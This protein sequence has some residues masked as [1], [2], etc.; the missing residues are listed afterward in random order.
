[1][2]EPD[3]KHTPRSRLGSQTGG[4]YR[5]SRVRSAST[6]L[7]SRGRVYEPAMVDQESEPTDEPWRAKLLVIGLALFA[8]IVA[9]ALL[10]TTPNQPEQGELLPRI[11][12]PLIWALAA[13]LTFIPLQIRLGLPNIGW[14]GMV[15][16]GL[17]AYLLAYVPAPTGPIFELP[18]LPV[19]L[20]LFLTTFYATVTVVMPI[21]YLVGQRIYKLRIDRFDAG[22]ARRQAYEVGLLVVASLIMAAMRVLSPLTFSLMA[23]IIVLVEALM[24]SRAKASK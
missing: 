10:L 24:L 5:P 13:G 6:Q 11:L 15:G 23:L 9:V 1:M 7:A 16:W 21:I 4:P 2:P 18:D 17:L 14:Q 12:T 8:W 22:R 20:L 19:Y 3:I